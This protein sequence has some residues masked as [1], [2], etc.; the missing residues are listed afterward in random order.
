MPLQRPQ[1]YLPL[2]PTD[3]VQRYCVGSRATRPTCQ[4]ARKSVLAQSTGSAS[5]TRRSSHIIYVV[6]NKLPLMLNVHI[7]E[8]AIHRDTKTKLVMIR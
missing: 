5:N 3:E 6:Q 8:K 2:P 1:E 7:I 4:G